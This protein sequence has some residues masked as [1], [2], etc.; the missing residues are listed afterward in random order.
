[1]KTSNP[2]KLDHTLARSIE[3]HT[4]VSDLVNEFKLCPEL[5]YVIAFHSGLL[6]MEHATAASKTQVEKLSSFRA[7][8]NTVYISDASNEQ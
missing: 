3:L 8:P 5:R 2:E 1:M 4:A 6:P 7:Q